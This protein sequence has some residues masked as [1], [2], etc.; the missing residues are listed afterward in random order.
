MLSNKLYTSNKLNHNKL[1][2]RPDINGGRKKV[3]TK[4]NERRDMIHVSTSTPLCATYIDTTYSSQTI[5]H[6][7]DLIQND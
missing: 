3:R 1:N 6:T 4:E 5:I 7:E 2:R